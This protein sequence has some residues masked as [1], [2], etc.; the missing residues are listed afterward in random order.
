[1]LIFSS[2]PILPPDE[3]ISR[4]YQDI[5]NIIHMFTSNPNDKN[6]YKDKEDT[7]QE[8]PPEIFADIID[9]ENKNSKI[10]INFKTVDALKNIKLEYEKQDFCT[11][12]DRKNFTPESEGLV[13]ITS[14]VTSCIKGL[15]HC[16]SKLNC[17]DILLQ[18]AENVSAENI[19]DRIIPYIVSLKSLTLNKQFIIFYL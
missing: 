10:K 1:M 16:T 14:L 19:L 7:K 8:P 18:L 2:Q 12:K 9:D 3:K 5:G 13:I 11:V 15:H 4:I 6:N 17:L